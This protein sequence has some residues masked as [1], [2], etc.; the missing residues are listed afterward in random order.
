MMCTSGHYAN[1]SGTVE[2]QASSLD[3][4]ELFVLRWIAVQQVRVTIDAG[5][6]P[7]RNKK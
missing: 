6:R 5:L 7:E 3:E 4:M 2:F 1:E